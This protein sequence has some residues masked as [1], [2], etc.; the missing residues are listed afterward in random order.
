MKLNIQLFGGVCTIESIN[1]TTDISTNASTFSIDVSLSSTG[2]TYNNSNASMELQWK[3]ASEGTWH[4][5]GRQTFSLPK[6]STR[7]KNWT[8]SLTHNQDGTLEEIQYRVDWYITNST[9]GVTGITSYT[10]T[11]IP[12]GSVF[13]ANQ[14]DKDTQ[15]LMTSTLSFPANQYVNNVYHKLEAR[16]MNNGTETTICT[17]TDVSIINNAIS[18][19]LS[20]GELSTI[21]NLMPNQTTHYIRMFLYTYTDSSYQ[22][23]LGDV[24]IVWWTGLIPTS[25]IPTAS[26]SYSEGGDVPS[27]W[28]L[29]VKGKSKV[30]FTLTGTGVYGSTITGYSISGDGYT[31]NSNTAIT[32]YLSTAG[33]ITFTG[34]VTDS[35]NRQGSIQSI[36]N[37]L[38]YYNPSFTATQVQRCDSQGNIDEN[39]EYLYYNFAGSISSCDGNNKANTTYKIGYRVQNTGNY[40][41]ITID[42]NK[43]SINASGVL[44]GV[45]FSSN[46]TYDIQFAIQDTFATS[47][48]LQTLDTGF[49]LMNFNASGKSMAIGKVSEASSTDELLEI[50][51]DTEVDGKVEATGSLITTG[52][53]TGVICDNQNATS[54]RKTKYT[55]SGGGR[56]GIYDMTNSSWIIQSETNQDVAIPHHFSTGAGTEVNLSDAYFY[57][58]RNNDKYNIISAATES[59][60]LRP[61]GR[62][63]GTGQTALNPNGNL[64]VSGSI[65]SNGKSV[66]VMKEL[67]SN[68]TGSQ[69]VNIGESTNNYNLYII[70][71]GI[72]ID[73]KRS[74]VFIPNFQRY[75]F[76]QIAT[77]DYWAVY[78]FNNSGNNITMTYRIG[79][80]W[81][82]TSKIYKII[83]VKF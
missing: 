75:N 71:W 36:L 21:Y 54:P 10:P 18:F 19:T 31:Y 6:T 4:G 39:G 32:N 29:W 81:S 23:Q 46:T 2:S 22:N 50:A 44:S 43:D 57:N 30:D 63:S 26:L 66:P 45:T 37:V 62:W 82:Q 79:Q 40:T 69:S 34:I 51:L 9:N 3:Y 78:E 11:T 77:K 83:G 70:T 16:F 33:A 74:D 27:T 80:G 38:D 12:R 35:R 58:G 8:M 59:I 25:I 28:G 68:T 20:S 14:W 48:S 56:A 60:Y 55:V 72:A 24:S 61:N 1:E 52:N 41:Y 76:T 42:S 67:Y 47:T 65:T 64:T 73:E 49:D 17:R 53:D 15:R 5:L 7:T 13:I